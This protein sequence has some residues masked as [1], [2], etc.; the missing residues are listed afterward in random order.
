MDLVFFGEIADFNRPAVTS[1]DFFPSLDGIILIANFPLVSSFWLAV[2]LFKVTEFFHGKI[3]IEFKAV[4]I[5]IKCA[6]KTHVGN[7]NN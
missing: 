6:L 7:G 2:K 4:E 3:I 1:Y 5:E